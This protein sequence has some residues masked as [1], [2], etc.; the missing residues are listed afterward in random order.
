MVLDDFRKDYLKSELIR[1]TQPNDLNDPFECLPIK[2]TLQNLNN[3][4]KELTENVNNGNKLL[5]EIINTVDYNLIEKIYSN[6]NTNVNN[7][8]VIFS[9]S[10][11]WNEILMWSHYADSHRGFCVGYDK[12]H[13]FFNN[14]ISPDSNTSK[15]VLEVIYSADRVQ[16]PMSFKDKKL[17]FEPFITKSLNWEYESE[18]R[19]IS[20][21]SLAD[22]TLKEEPNDICLF[23]IP[24]SAIKEIILGANIISENEIMLNKFCK[25]RNI[26]IYKSK[27]SEINFEMIRT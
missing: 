27:I 8:I 1:F 23:K 16:I 17:E 2:P 12:N 10:K 13:T 20:S 9:L 25:E 11:K 24:H 14:Y 7:D 19:I 4:K 5:Q 15:T 22:L 21:I 26:D 18:V 3:L 6:A